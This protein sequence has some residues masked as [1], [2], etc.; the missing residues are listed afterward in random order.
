MLA[1]GHVAS[2]CNSSKNVH[3]VRDRPNKELFRISSTTKYGIFV[4]MNI[5]GKDVL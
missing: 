2:V 3:S 4:T 1:K 5:E